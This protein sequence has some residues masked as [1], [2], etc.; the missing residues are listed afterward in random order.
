MASG[1]AERVQ[2]WA[3]SESSDTGLSEGD[4][5]LQSDGETA[6][7]LVV[8]QVLGKGNY[9]EIGCYSGY[10]SSELSDLDSSVF[11]DMELNNE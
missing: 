5:D 7:Q 6:Q 11:G 4:E 1:R 2:D 8:P 9:K 10:Y 3:G